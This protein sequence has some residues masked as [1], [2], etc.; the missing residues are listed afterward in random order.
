MTNQSRT[1]A[2]KMSGQKR[3][4]CSDEVPLAKKRGVSVKTVQKW[5]T[6]SDREMSTSV[7]LKYMY[8]KADRDYVAMLKCSMCIQFN[9]KLRGMCY[10]QAVRRCSWFEEPASV[11]LQRSCCY[12]HAQASNASFEE[13]ELQ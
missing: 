10:S 9:E 7:W 4:A 13:A 1:H 3:A 2:D 11:Q 6:E 12:R 5:I 8:E